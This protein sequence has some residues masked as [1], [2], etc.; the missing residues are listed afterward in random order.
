MAFPSVVE[1][2]TYLSSNASLNSWTA[3]SSKTVAVGEL[4]I[5]VVASD[6]GPILTTTSSG[7]SKLDQGYAGIVVTGAIFYKIA[8]STTETFDLSSTSAEA[9]SGALYRITGADSLSATL[10]GNTSSALSFDPPSH[11]AGAS[12]D[13]LWIAAAC[14]DNISTVT[15]FPSGYSNTMSATAL[16][17]NG[18]S[19]AVG[20]KTAT[21]QTEDPTAFTATGTSRRAVGV[22]IAAWRAG[23][24][25]NPVYRGSSSRASRYKGAKSDANLYKGSRGMGWT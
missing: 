7:W 9:Y 2:S 21:A 19:I 20:S 25:S 5:F 23:G 3:F 13:H 18:T 1:V 14:I 4:L 16:G 17:G 12:R 11:N 24:G 15:G 6:A 10:V 22:T 8:T